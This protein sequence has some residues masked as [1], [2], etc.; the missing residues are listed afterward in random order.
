MNCTD[1][2]AVGLRKAF[3]GATIETIDAR[4]DGH[5]PI[6]LTRVRHAEP[7][8]GVVE[9]MPS[10]DSCLIGMSLPAR[11]S[12]AEQGVDDAAF[13][14]ARIAVRI[15]QEDEPFRADLHEPFDM[16]F[17]A[18]PRRTLVGLAAEMRKGGVRELACPDDSHDAVLQRL[19]G[20]LLTAAAGTSAHSPLLAGHVARAIQIHLIQ[21][22][23]VAAPNVLAKGGLAGWQLER[24]KAILTTNVAGEVPIS[25]VASACGLSRSYFIK[26]FRQTVGTTPHRWLLEHKIER[27][28]HS[29]LSKSEPIADIAHQCG[30]ADQAHLTRVFTSMIGTPP[31]AWRRVNRR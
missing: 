13:S 26:A 23:G 30:F 28:K 27:V 21:K 17:H 24:A 16:L 18:L 25:E 20:V 22:Y 1:V 4:I 2:A 12:F 9:F 6:V 5:A 15:R 31:A 7:G 3:C 14:E 11:A 10:S 19:V 8:F 29:L